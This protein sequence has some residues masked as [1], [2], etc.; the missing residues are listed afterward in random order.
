VHCPA[1]NSRPAQPRNIV[2]NSFGAAFACGAMIS[3]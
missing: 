3:M 1:D 2:T